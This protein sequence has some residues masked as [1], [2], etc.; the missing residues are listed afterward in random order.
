MN[1]LA[2]KS[3]TGASPGVWVEDDGS[4]SAAKA[5]LLES[6]LPEDQVHPQSLASNT[7]PAQAGCLTDVCYVNMMLKNHT[8]K[9]GK[10]QQPNTALSNES[11]HI[12]ISFLIKKSN[13]EKRLE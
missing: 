2:R 6:Q 10:S 13:V 9:H 7:K 4:V 5:G 3:F 8:M 12:R 1:T 11:L